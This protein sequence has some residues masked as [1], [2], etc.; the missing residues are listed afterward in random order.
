MITWFAEQVRRLYDVVPVELHVDAGEDGVHHL[1]VTEP[2]DAQPA[3]P[4]LVTR[5]RA[6]ANR[7]GTPTVTAMLTVGQVAHVGELLGTTVIDAAAMRRLADH[8]LRRAFPSDPPQDALDT[9]G[10]FDP[11]IGQGWLL[12]K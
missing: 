4:E 7:T 9:I 6:R 8:Q 12:D 3:P 2:S 1:T 5:F 10:L 11:T